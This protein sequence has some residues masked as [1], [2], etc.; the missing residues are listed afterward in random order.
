MKLHE[1]ESEQHSTRADESPFQG[2]TLDMI[3][4]K[5]LRCMTVRGLLS[6]VS[7]GGIE[8]GRGPAP[9]RESDTKNLVIFNDRTKTEDQ[10][11]TKFQSD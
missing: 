8:L 6:A 4:G 2:I 3:T 11:C 5:P 7:G 9:T 1:F 10:A